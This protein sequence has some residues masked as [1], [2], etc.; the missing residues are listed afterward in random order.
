LGGIMD[1]VGNAGVGG[2]N[3]GEVGDV[4]RLLSHNAD[5]AGRAR[6]ITSLSWQTT[7]GRRGASSAAQGFST[8]W[9][10]TVPW[11]QT[12]PG[13]I[14]GGRSGLGRNCPRRPAG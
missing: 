1:A 5:S 4:G 6:P 3:D 2:G 7:I 11:N 9:A 10:K 12:M 13:T 14:P 8:N